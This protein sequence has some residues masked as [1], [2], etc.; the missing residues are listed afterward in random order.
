M[1]GCL[2]RV[3][4]KVVDRLASAVTLTQLR[5]FDLILGPESPTL[6]DKKREAEHER[7]QEAFPGVDFEGTTIVTGSRANVG[8]SRDPSQSI[9][10][11]LALFGIGAGR[12]VCVL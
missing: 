10:V 9:N 2:D 5:F 8:G 6:A 1:I 7:L 12:N 11:R 3:Y 4:W